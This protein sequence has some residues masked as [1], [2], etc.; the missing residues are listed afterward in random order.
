MLI[1]LAL[2]HHIILMMF[3]VCIWYIPLLA[4]LL[5]YHL[6]RLIWMKGMCPDGIILAAMDIIHRLCSFECLI[7]T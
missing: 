1:D 6:G 5:V 2:S 7:C 4:H 3:P